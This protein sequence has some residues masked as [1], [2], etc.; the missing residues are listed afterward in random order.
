MKNLTPTQKR[1]SLAHLVILYSQCGYEITHLMGQPLNK[2]DFSKI[3]KS[4]EE[5]IIEWEE[6]N[7]CEYETPYCYEI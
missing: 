5:L 6:I 7:S 4:I 3:I 2:F 1:K